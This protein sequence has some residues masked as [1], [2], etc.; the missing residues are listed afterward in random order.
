[1]LIQFLK[2]DFIESII[3]FFNQKE[4]AVVGGTKVHLNQD[5]SISQSHE[6]YQDMEYKIRFNQD[7]LGVMC[8]TDG[9]CTA[10]GRHI[11]GRDEEFEDVDQVVCLLAKNKGL[12]SP[13]HES[14][15]LKDQEK[16]LKRV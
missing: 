14:N 11:L 5:S 6:R 9:P 10:Y 4:V 8:K 12:I 2:K 3:P 1:M 16:Q 7:I 13:L 15:M